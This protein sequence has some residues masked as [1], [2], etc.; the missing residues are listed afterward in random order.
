[1]QNDVVVD[2][3]PIYSQQKDSKQTEELMA[4]NIVR[5]GLKL[6]CIQMINKW[7]IVCNTLLLIFEKDEKQVKE[8]R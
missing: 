8:C 3:F 7:L 4:L 2:G 1:M 5:Q 6:N